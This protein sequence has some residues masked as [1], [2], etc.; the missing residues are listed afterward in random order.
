MWYNIFIKDIIWLKAVQWDFQRQSKEA[1]STNRLQKWSIL[2]DPAS[3]EIISRLSNT[4]MLENLYKVRYI[5]SNKNIFE[6]KRAA[7]NQAS[8][9]HQKAREKLLLKSFENPDFT[10]FNSNYD[11]V[12][13]KK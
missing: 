9:Y 2:V 4:V 1:G 6:G 12:V 5:I 11:D 13:V 3:F 8:K 10:T 7:W